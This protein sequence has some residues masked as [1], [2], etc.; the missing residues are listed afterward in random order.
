MH[1]TNALLSLCVLLATNISASP[2][3]PAYDNHGHDCLTEGEATYL[4]NTLQYF[5]VKLNKQLAEKTLTPDFISQSDSNNLIF[6]CFGPGDGHGEPVGAHNRA[7]FINSQLSSQATTPVGTPN[8]FKTLNSWFGCNH[9]AFRWINFFGTDDP[10]AT[11]AIP[12]QGIDV[13]D[14][15]K[16]NGKWLIKTDY[17]EWNALA[18]VLGFG[19]KLEYPPAFGGG[20]CSASGL[21]S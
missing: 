6:G 20:S 16:K 11:K 15:V 2:T 8:T 18:F 13:L 4:I 14:V 3:S 19:G 7:E 9:I 21:G 1:I 10:S 17:S 12:S 5:Y